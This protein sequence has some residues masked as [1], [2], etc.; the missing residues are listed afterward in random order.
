[1]RV[2]VTSFL[3][4]EGVNFYHEV[5]KNTWFHSERYLYDRYT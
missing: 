2:L 4:Q 5:K 1:M 3:S